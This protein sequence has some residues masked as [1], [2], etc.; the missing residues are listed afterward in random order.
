EGA[1]RWALGSALGARFGYRL[2]ATGF[3][4]RLDFACR[5]SLKA[6]AAFAI[7]ERSFRGLRGVCA[8][9][10]WS[11]AARELSI[12]NDGQKPRDQ[13]G[14]PRAPKGHVEAGRPSRAPG[15]PAGAPWSTRRRRTLTLSPA[16]G[17]PST[18]PGA[19]LRSARA[20]M[21]VRRAESTRSPMPFA[22]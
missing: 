2:L 15:C 21:E 12:P 3:R 13:R 6:E 17:R 4:K 7:R 14:R 16:K 18:S 1:P 19:A 9:C 10:R 8:G 5:R 22:P 11:L 20:P